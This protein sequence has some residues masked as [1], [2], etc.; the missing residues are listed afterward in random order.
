MHLRPHI[1][2]FGLVELTHPHP[3]LG[4][5]L[6]PALGEF[7][8][9]P[10]ADLT[11]SK[12]MNPLEALPHL[13]FGEMLPAES[14]NVIQFAPDG[15]VLFGALRRQILGVSWFKAAKLHHVS[16]AGCNYRWR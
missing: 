16:S 9:G 7:V 11:E 10:V 12:L 15:A 6:T 1:F 8:V 4:E 13:E 5:P 2:I 3:A 14:V